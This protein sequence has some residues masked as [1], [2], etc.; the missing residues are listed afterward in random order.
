MNVTAKIRL[1]M[2]AVADQVWRH[3]LNQTMPI[4]ARFLTKITVKYQRQAVSKQGQ[5][6]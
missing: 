6:S 5:T 3:G 1:D 2:D 4:S